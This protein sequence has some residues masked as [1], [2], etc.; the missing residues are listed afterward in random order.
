MCNY[1]YVQHF[2]NIVLLSNPSPCFPLCPLPLCG[3]P[4]LLLTWNPLFLWSWCKCPSTLVPGWWS[5]APP[6]APYPPPP[7]PT[8]PTVHVTCFSKTTSQHQLYCLIHIV[9]SC[10]LIFCLHQLGAAPKIW[11]DSS[12][13]SPAHLRA[14]PGGDHRLQ[15]TLHSLK[16]GQEVT[17]YYR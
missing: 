6:L 8:A 11:K 3:K 7:L 17:T 12:S 14:W 13:S 10:L 15:V 1:I 5:T 9:F 16:P 2:M 4:P